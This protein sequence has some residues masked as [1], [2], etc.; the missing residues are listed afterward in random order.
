MCEKYYLCSTPA[1]GNFISIVSPLSNHHTYNDALTCDN[2]HYG[3]KYHQKSIVF[4]Q[5]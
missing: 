2:S 5:I 3:N 4:I 1:N